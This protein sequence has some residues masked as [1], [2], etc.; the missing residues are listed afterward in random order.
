MKYIVIELQESQNGT[1]GNFVFSYDGRN[2]AEG[3][4]HALLSAAAESDVRKHSAVLLTSEGTYI[5]SR[6]YEH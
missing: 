1:V 5:E 6:C 4:Y 3:K 2:A